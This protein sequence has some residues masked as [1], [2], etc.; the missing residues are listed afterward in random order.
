LKDML[1]LNLSC[2]VR[3]G[4]LVTSDLRAFVLDEKLVTD[5]HQKPFL[6]FLIFYNGRNHKFVDV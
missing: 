4:Y 1:A 3:V 2:D 6:L 5:L